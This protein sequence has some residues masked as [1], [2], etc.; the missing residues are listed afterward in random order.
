MDPLIAWCGHRGTFGGAE[1]CGHIAYMLGGEDLNTWNQCGLS[2]VV[3]GD[4]DRLHSGCDGCCHCRQHTFDGSEASV[5]AQ[6]GQEDDLVCAGEVT[7][8]GPCAG[9]YGQVEA[10]S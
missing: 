1:G 9:E 4:D 3:C 7:V 10:G 6:F 2:G 8:G 5:Q